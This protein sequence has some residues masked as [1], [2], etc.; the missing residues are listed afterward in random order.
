MAH[1]I[2]NKALNFKDTIVISLMTFALFLGAGNVIFPPAL[3]LEAGTNLLLAMSGFLFTAVGLPAFALIV[4]GMVGKAENITSPLTTGLSRIF[5]IAL[6]VA[7][8]PAFAM[9]RAITV[10]YEMGLRPFVDG[11]YLLPFTIVFSL[12]TLLLAFNS[13]KL[14]DYIGKIMTPA[15]IVMLAA[16]AVAALLF[17]LGIPAAPTVGYKLAPVTEGIMQ[18]YM[19]MDALG[20]VGFGWVII[21]A[22]NSK[23][24]TAQK[25]VAKSTLHIAGIYCVL[26]GGCYLAL[27]YVGATA[28]TIAAG[29]TNGGEILSLYV[30]GI[31]GGFGQLLL[32]GIIILACLSTTIGLTQANAEY[33]NSTFNLSMK[34]VSVAVVLVTCIVANFGLEQIISL[35]LPAILVLCP[36]AIALVIASFVSHLMPNLQPAH[37][38]VMILTIVFG[39]IDAMN[40]MG[41]IPESMDAVFSG[42]LPLYS[43]NASWLLPCLVAIAVQSLISTFER[44][45]G[46][47][48]RSSLMNKRFM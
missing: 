40:I 37:N 11:N 28:S 45:S 7:I 35:S 18:G 3:G 36:V 46:K 19:T 33:F 42:S 38:A 24:V 16:I 25:Q 14:V 6:F 4:L 39:G 2:N 17:P 21:R 5:W 29:A 9:P 10:A 13:Q 20:A 12:F 27:G 31:F 26:M 23:G 41:M 43:A 15:M 8:G 32:A 47:N 48:G 30:H 34:K 1:P 22:I 44:F